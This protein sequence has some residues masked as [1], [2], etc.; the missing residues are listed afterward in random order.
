[1]DDGA[2]DSRRW[3]D[4]AKGQ[5]VSATCESELKYQE[6]I[7]FIELEVSRRPQNYDKIR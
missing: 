4:E 6:A 5:H 2:T 3:N 7:R 1:V